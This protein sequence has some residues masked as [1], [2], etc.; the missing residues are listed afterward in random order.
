MSLKA[1]LVATVAEALVLYAICHVDI[2]Y[3]LHKKISLTFC[4][5]RTYALWHA[6]YI[7]TTQKVKDI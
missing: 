4:V 5:A 2:V 6:D 3:T 1:A 7:C